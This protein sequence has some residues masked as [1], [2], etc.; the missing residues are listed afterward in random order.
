MSTRT[1]A[2]SS[3][4]SHVLNATLVLRGILSSRPTTLTTAT[5]GATRSHSSCC[6]SLRY[7]QTSDNRGGPCA[8][9]HSISLYLQEFLSSIQSNS[10]LFRLFSLSCTRLG[11]YNNLHR[12]SF[13]S[14]S[15]TPSKCRALPRTL[16]TKEQLSHQVPSHFR[17]EIT[18]IFAH[19]S[20]NTKIPKRTPPHQPTFRAPV[21]HTAAYAYCSLRSTCINKHFRYS[22][23]I[24]LTSSMSWRCWR[25][26]VGAS[27]AL[28]CLV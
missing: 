19:Y 2:Y 18:E 1:Q 4:L 8:T 9:T 23:H 10:L 20:S 28:V 15:R 5:A 22:W 7:E 6:R 17:I 21:S 12:S 16:P 24:R 25:G 14:P 3:N 26:Y 11:P 13:S 27:F